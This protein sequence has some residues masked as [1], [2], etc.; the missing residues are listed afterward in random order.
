MRHPYTRPLI[1]LTT[2]AESARFGVWHT[3]S[4]VLPRTYPDA[5][6]RAGGV[7]V[8]L[9]PVAEGHRELLSAV[10]ALVLTGG[11]DVDPA[12]YGAAPH[13]SVRPQPERD[14]FEFALLELAL[15]ARIPVLGVCR[16]MQLLNV[17]L[18]GTLVQHLPDTVGTTV[19]RPAPASFGPG[20]ALL[21]PGSRVAAILG[22]ETFCRCHHHQAVDRPG[23]GLVVVGRAPDGTV[24]AVE[25]PGDPFVVGVQ[26]HPEEQPDDLRLFTVLVRETERHRKEQ[27]C[28]ALPV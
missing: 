20:R 2:S 8:L 22:A 17:A 21:T 25:R 12:R 7:P 5:V 6:V 15:A 23:D 10:D 13:P 14:D 26:W 1:G 9:A 11:A 3:E 19:H 28:S 18:G 4:S 27:P 24:E 16:G